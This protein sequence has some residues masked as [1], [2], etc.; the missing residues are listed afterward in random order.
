MRTFL[1]VFGKNHIL[2]RAKK[3]K[4]WTIRRLIQL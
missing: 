4:N 2:S 1:T 3:I